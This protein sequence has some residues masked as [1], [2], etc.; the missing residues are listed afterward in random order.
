MDE[1]HESKAAKPIAQYEF[2]PVKGVYSIGEYSEMEKEKFHIYKDEQLIGTAESLAMAKVFLEG[3]VRK[4]L[5]DL[6]K[7]LDLLKLSVDKNLAWIEDHRKML[8]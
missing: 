8:Q 4:D 2:P 5:S 6:E 7:E 1:Y 3:R